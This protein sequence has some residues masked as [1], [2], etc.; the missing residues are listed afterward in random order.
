MKVDTRIIVIPIKTWILRQITPKNGLRMREIWFL[1]V[2]KYRLKTKVKICQNNQKESCSLCRDLQNDTRSI[3]NKNCMQK[4]FQ[5]KNHLRT[6]HYASHTTHNLT[7]RSVRIRV[8]WHPIRRTC[9]S[10]LM[11][12]R[13]YHSQHDTHRI[14]KTSYK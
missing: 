10:F 3:E 9:G 14:P 13:T 6:Q 5:S 11:E 7:S 2:I 12:P 8:T 4:N 1:T